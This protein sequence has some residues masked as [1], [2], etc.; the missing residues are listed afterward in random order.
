MKS[1]LH[2]PVVSRRRRLFWAAAGLV[3]VAVATWLVLRGP[4]WLLMLRANYHEVVAASRNDSAR[5]Q[6][7]VR[8]YA[9]AARLRPNDAAL[10]RLTGELLMDAR[11]LLGD[12]GEFAGKS[13]RAQ[14]ELERAHAL[15]PD[16]V[17]TLL[18]LGSLCAVGAG[19]NLER[20]REWLER[21]AALAPKR[22]DA[23]NELGI[24]YYRLGRMD[25]ARACFEK[26][27]A[28]AWPVLDRFE[29][30]RAKE[31]L[32]R[33]HLAQ[34]E[35]AEA[36]S[37]LQDVTK[38]LD[39]RNPYWGCPYQALGELYTRIGNPSKAVENYQ[40]AANAE[41]TKPEVQFEAALAC[42]EAGDLAG[43]HEYVDRALALAARRPYQVL[44]GF[45]LFT[46]QQYEAAASAFGQPAEADA[47]V[48]AGFGHLA[49][50]RQDY[51]EAERRFAPVLADAQVCTFLPAD[52]AKL[53][54]ANAIGRYQ[55]FVCNLAAQGMGWALANQNRHEEAIAYYERILAWQPLDL[56]ALLGQGNSLSGLKRLDEAEAVFAALLRHYPDS[57]YA[58]AEMALVKYNKGDDAAAEDYF[59]RALARD[60][61]NYTCPYEG[62]GLLYL[63]QGKTAQAQQNFQK[64]IEIN[65][66]IE[67]KK[68]N[69]L[70]KIR[71]REGR[72]DEAR[73]LLEQSVRNYP[74]DPEAKKLL[75][76]L[77]RQSPANP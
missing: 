62:L 68:Y 37:L 22:A 36:E 38:D 15:D 54:R 11:G 7:A 10:H 41:P 24:L 30:D 5:M 1:P 58:L 46:Q 14:R 48:N 49:I 61:R 72:I 40:R 35:Y 28:N 6:R 66:S 26:A 12:D 56:L 16:N 29:R 71:L 25:A 33:I 39:K 44:Q 69:G 21:A 42:F 3:V 13:E 43:A 17:E 31:F 18:L 55:I 73:R 20:A 51:R 45:V 32:G 19:Q 63:R 57:P 9:E 75:Q 64:A 50:V 34:G 60:D 8:L 67:Y 65:P 70:A 47:G 52:H 2:Q 4:A 74:Y 53:A 76:E 27:Q 59:R 77:A 23:Q